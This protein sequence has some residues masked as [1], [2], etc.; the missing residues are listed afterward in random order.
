MAI[1]PQFALFWGVADEG[2]IKSYFPN[3]KSHTKVTVIL[4]QIISGGL[5]ANL[6]K[7]QALPVDIGPDQVRVPVV[8]P[9]KMG[10]GKSPCTKCA[11][12]VPGH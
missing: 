12:I 10:I 3:T 5:V 1:H 8:A 9:T 11:P 6:V 7:A 4:L 2:H